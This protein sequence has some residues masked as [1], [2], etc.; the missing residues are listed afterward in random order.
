MFLSL[1][2]MALCRKCPM[3]PT[4][5]SL[6]LHKLCALQVPP[7]Q[8]ARAFMLQWG[9]LLWVCCG[10]SGLAPRP[11][12]FQALP[13]VEAAS[14]WVQSDLDYMVQRVPRLGPAHWLVELDW[15]TWLQD[16]G[17]VLP[18][19]RLGQCSRVAGCMTKRSQGWCWH[20]G[21]QTQVQGYRLQ[22][23]MVPGAGEA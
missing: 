18:F 13:Q 16:P 19:W 12:G 9:Q 2:E 21:E 10:W 6:W 7:M 3:G 17:L 22:V 8:A 23:L 11:A 14:P 5:H 1:G 15:G 20:T 4:A